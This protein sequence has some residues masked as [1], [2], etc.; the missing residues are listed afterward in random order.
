MPIPPTPPLI[1]LDV[2]QAELDLFNEKATSVKRQL[3]EAKSSLASTKERIKDRKQSVCPLLNEH[4][5]LVLHTTP[6]RGS[7]SSFALNC[8]LVHHS[9]DGLS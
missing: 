6:T 5:P 9:C 7:A 1:Q 8:A 2:A 4:L 3:E